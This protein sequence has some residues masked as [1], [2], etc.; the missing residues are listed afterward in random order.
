MTIYAGSRF[1][2]VTP[3]R[4]EEGSPYFGRVIPRSQTTEYVEYY[5]SEGDRID[6]LASDFLGDPTRW[7]EIAAINPE[8]T[9]FEGMPPNTRLRIPRAQSG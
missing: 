1:E 7:W 5:T 4:D 6:L 8:V 3:L 2:G 9:D